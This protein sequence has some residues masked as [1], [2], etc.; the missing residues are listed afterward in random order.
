MNEAELLVMNEAE[1]LGR[2]LVLVAHPDD[3][4]AGCGVL[5]Q[6]MREPVVVFATDGAP[7]SEFFWKRYGSRTRYAQLRQEEAYAALARAGL[8]EILFM[9]ET[10]R[11]GEL[12]VDQE[13]HL[14]IPQALAELTAIVRRYRP[15][16]LLT[17]AYEGGHP[18]HDVCSFLGTVLARQHGLPAWEFP[19]Y[20]RANGEQLVFQ[21]FLASSGG[22]EALLQITPREA[23][24]KRR[25]LA[26]YPS[27]HGFLMSFTAGIERF[28]PQPLYDYSR[29]PHTGALNYETWQWPVT[30]KEVCNALNAFREAQLQ[31]V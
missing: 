31:A 7:R 14:A 3:E 30:G 29:P 18:D 22:E 12:F 23:E 6:R 10:V 15:Q 28:R 8:S 24:T 1:L 26:A 25:M 2:T 13:L 21:R 11:P 17:M 20:H 27:Q 19:L 9:A 5:L 4:S 16:A